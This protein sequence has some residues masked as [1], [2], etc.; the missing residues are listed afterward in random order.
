MKHLVLLSGGVD[1]TTCLGKVCSEN[2]KK[3][4]VAVSIKY[5][6][7]HTKELECAKNI[8]NWYQVKHIILDLSNIF[9]FSNCSLLKDS[10]EQIPEKSYAEQIKENGEGKVT[11]Y[12]P[13]RNGLML[14]SM[15]TLA[16][17][18]FPDECCK[19][20]IGAHSDDAAG[21]AY[22]DC[23]EGFIK[24]MSE[25]IHLGTYQKVSIYSPLV[26]LNKSQVVG[27]GLRLNVPYRL[28]WSCYQGGN[29]PCGV[30]GTCIDRQNAFKLNGM[31]DPILNVSTKN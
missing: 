6:Q 25:A 22:A 27:M 1:S 9:K 19:I 7:K 20:V 15:A 14:S 8:A 5:G 4:V 28:T 26:S 31:E 10:T 13:F 2:S 30:C 3:D 21:N 11:T 17:S 18:I 12:V 24:Y 29:K 16:Q 23:S